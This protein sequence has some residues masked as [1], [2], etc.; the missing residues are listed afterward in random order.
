MQEEATIVFDALDNHLIKTTSCPVWICQTFTQ[1]NTGVPFRY[2][3]SIE[4][5]TQKKILK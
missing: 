5:I 1:V 4:G 2:A 3:K